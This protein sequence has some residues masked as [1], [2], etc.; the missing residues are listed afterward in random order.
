MTKILHPAKAAKCSKRQ[1]EAFEQIGAGVSS[2]SGY[3]AS[4]FE[5]L[6]AKGLIEICGVKTLGRDYFG[7]I[8]IPEFQQPLPVHMQ[9][10]QWC[11]ENLTEEDLEIINGD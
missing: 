9:W 10:C 1:I 6:L 3:A 11:S 8:Q 2:P 7:K 5:S 4:V